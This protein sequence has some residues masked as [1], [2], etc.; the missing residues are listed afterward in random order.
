MTYHMRDR[1]K[2]TQF[3]CLVITVTARSQLKDS[4]RLCLHEACMLWRK[5]MLAALYV[6]F[7]HSMDIFLDSLLMQKA[8]QF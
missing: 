4:R 5:Y 1:L 7:Y 2:T 3:C 6:T 8:H